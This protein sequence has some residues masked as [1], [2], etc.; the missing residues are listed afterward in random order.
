MLH[1]DALAHPD[2][3]TTPPACTGELVVDPRWSPRWPLENL[4]CSACGV[5]VAT[6][7]GQVHW[8]NHEWPDPD[9]EAV[10][11]PSDP[12]LDAE[13]DAFLDSY[14]HIEGLKEWMKPKGS[15]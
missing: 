11:L 7:E 2:A 3:E 10:S 1:H 14:E 4:R 5:L 15:T 12:D 13:I 9:P 8:R 6:V